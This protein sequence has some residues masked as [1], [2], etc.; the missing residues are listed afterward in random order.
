MVVEYRNPLIITFEGGEGCGKTTQIEKFAPWFRENY[1]PCIAT[2][3][4][5]GDAV[6][7]KIRELLLDPNLTIHSHAELFL[8]EA[9]RDQFMNN[10][11]KPNIDKNISVLSDRFYDSTMAY[12][13]YGRRIRKERI[14]YLNEMV[15]GLRAPNLTFVIDINPERG[16]ENALMRGK[17][18]RID[19]ESLEFHTRVNNGFLQI[20]KENPDRCVLI[21]Y[22]EGIEKVQSKIREEFSSKFL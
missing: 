16:L 12:Q 3:E 15:V 19:A 10:I 6:G 7:E 17:L 11:I 20:A 13:S 14:N 18:S 8:F 22:E 1:G 9:A 4:P 5:G 21:Q 2:K